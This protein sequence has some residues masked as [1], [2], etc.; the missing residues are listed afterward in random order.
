MR[1]ILLLGG[2]AQQV[3][4]IKIAKRLGYHTVLCDYLSDNPGQ[5]HA[6]T[7]Y[8]VSTTDYEAVLKIAMEEQVDGVL[9]YASDPA[10]PTAAYI[11]E[12]MHIITNPYQSVEILCNKDKFRTFLKNNGFSVPL[13]QGYE[14][15]DDAIEGLN[16]GKFCFP[17][18]IKPVDSS[19]SKGATVL[20]SCEGVDV[21]LEL[22]FSF[23]RGH[24]IIVEEFIQKRHPYLVGGDIF[25]ADG[26]IAVWG[27]LNCQRDNAVNPLVPVG[28][29]YPLEMDDIDV[30][31]IKDTLE[32]LVF[33]LGIRNGAMNIE[34]V[35]D[36]NNHVHLIDVG[37]RSGG[38]MI[39]DLLSDMFGID[40]VELSVQA[41]MGVKLNIQAKTPKGCYATHN[42]HSNQNGIYQGITF[43]SD[44][45]KFIYR[46]HFYKK[47]G[48]PV[49]Y[50]DNAA[51]CL[52]IIFMKFENMTQMT[53]MLNNMNDH[54][55][56]NI[57]EDIKE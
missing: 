1:K 36:A 9:A 53:D 22:A 45:D 13:S 28:K 2:S 11:G 20:H 10:A 55:Q 4:A 21:A 24:R 35:V 19:G 8:S 50:F 27:L 25:V 41:A 48:D 33:K 18:I 5:Y 6:D 47:Q 42:L 7:Y 46:K 12:K 52:G 15:T 17:I 23:S 26:R 54:I 29:S 31:R 49:E 37:P 40:I 38:N 43:T 34:L 44:I 51:K 57:L 39:P 56:I 14:S 30:K 3:V 16:S 32:R